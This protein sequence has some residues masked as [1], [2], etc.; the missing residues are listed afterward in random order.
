MKTKK[1]MLAIGII[2]IIASLLKL[3]TMAG[4]IP[5]E[6][7]QLRHLV[8][9]IEPYFAPMLIFALGIMLTSMGLKKDDR[10]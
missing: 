6:C 10:N 4:I 5:A 1:L 7:L 9:V 8:S 2:F 3:A